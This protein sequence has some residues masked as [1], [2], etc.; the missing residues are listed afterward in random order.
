MS[1]KTQENKKKISAKSLA[2]R[3]LVENKHSFDLNPGRFEQAAAFCEDYKAFLDAAKT[4]RLAVQA[5]VLRLEAAGYRSFKRGEP[6]KAGDKIYMIN[7]ERALI[8]ATVGKKAVGQGTRLSIAHIDSPRLDLKPNPL[9]EN[10]ELVYFKTHYYGGVRK[11]QWVAMPLAMHGVVVTAQGKSVEIHL[12][13][14]PGEPGF[15]ITDLLPHLA[16]E[17]NKRSLGEGIKGEELNI[18]AGSLPYADEEGKER[19]KLETLRLLNEKYGITEQDFVRAEIEFVPAYKARDLGFDRSMI[20]AYG[21]DD[22]VCAY[23]ALA[24]EIDTRAPSYT[25]VCVLTD[26]E[27]T[28]SDGNTGLAGEFLFHFLQDLA[29]AQGEDYRSLLQ[30]SVCLSADVNVALDPTFPDVTERRNTARLNGGLVLTKYTGARGKSGTS[31]ASAEYMGYVTG[32]LDAAGVAW[33]VGELGKVDMGGG[34]TIAKFV[35]NRNIDVVDIGVPVLSMHSPYEVTAKLD[36][37][38]AYLAFLAFAKHGKPFAH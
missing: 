1:E 29:E 38:N 34:G 22:R 37:Y 4:E 9:Y 32:L 16:A 28:G 26:K 11:Y 2:K 10:E 18:L 3:L 15:T 35:A 8:A 17:Q 19:V 36:V 20:S 21:Q 13:E 14:E 33:Q 24:A 25:S 12:G 30:N 27:E 5:A 31:D 23:T 6:L 7:R